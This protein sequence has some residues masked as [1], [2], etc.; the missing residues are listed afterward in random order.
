MAAQTF[1]SVT[2][3]QDKYHPAIS[4]VGTPSGINLPLKSKKPVATHC[5]KVHT[6]LPDNVYSV[7]LI[8][9][10]TPI[11][12][13]HDSIPANWTTSFV[14]QSVSKMQSNFIPER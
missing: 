8:I 2:E 10:D 1:S 9:I 12:F 11:F 3:S 4:K 7:P 5:G 13:S 6:L 14:Y